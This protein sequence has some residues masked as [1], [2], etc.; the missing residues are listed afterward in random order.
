MQ[1]SMFDG[2]KPF[3]VDKPLRLITL[4]SGYDSQA[5]ALKYI[6]VPFE[7]YRTCEWAIPSIQALK[8]L[9]FENDDTDY[10]VGMSKAQLVETLYKSGV[11][12]DY[13]VPL[14]KEQ[15]QRYGESKL[16]KIYNNIRAC[17]NLVS[18]C[19]AKGEDLG[20]KET[21]KY[22]YLLTYSFPCQDLSAAGLG[23]GME[24]GSGTRSGMLW[25]VE[26][27][28]KE[29]KELP[30]VLLMENV[31]QVIGQ[32][33]IKAF[34]E[35][36]AF[37]DELG[38]H[39]KWQVINATEFSIPQNRERCFMVSVLGNHYYE[40][41][42]VIGNKLQ[43]KDVLE[44]NVAER[45]YLSEKIVETSYNRNILNAQKGGGNIKPKIMEEKGYRFYNQA[46]ET[47][48]DNDCKV[49]YIVDAFNKKINDSGITPTITTRPEGFKTAILL[50]DEPSNKQD[51]ME[52]TEMKEYQ[53]SDKMKKYI[54][55][56]DD[57][58]IVND[59]A[60]TLNKEIA[61]AITTREGCAR[62]DSCSYISDELPQN[63]NIANKD[64]T[65]YQI[66]K[67]TERE[68]G[69]LMGV[70][71]DDISKIG[72]NLSRSAQYHTFGDSIVTAC[73]MAI[74]GKM[75]NVDYE[76]KIKELT[77]KIT[78]EG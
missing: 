11:S 57:R 34:A 44:K 61:P 1:I 37:L 21:N 49:G 46:L 32:K 8:D 9:H 67:L 70:K 66:R 43:L 16:R 17:H 53:L 68:C 24:R 14:T 29:T 69:R 59:N 26:R 27:L 47:I 60:L 12:A 10:S 56:Y 74:F 2:D 30:Q 62:A 50:I 40:F 6:G 75:F 22:C 78:G 35:W 65:P 28:L 33:N 19:N 18:I 39:S 38:Y 25:E 77:K 4:F 20:I 64:I 15:L 5:L 76:S 31:K 23:K 63:Y 72:K 36:V 48:K 41:P 55:S 51:R 73:L 45:Y 7:H 42:K 13:N 52:I 58:Y 3:K 54:N 71:D